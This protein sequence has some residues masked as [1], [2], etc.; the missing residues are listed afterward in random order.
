[1]A[2]GRGGF[3]L[4]ELMIAMSLLGI[5]A[6]AIHETV[7][8]GLRAVRVSHIREDVR[9]QAVRALDRLTREAALCANVDQAQ[10][11][12]FQFDADLD[13]DGSTE[14]NINYR[15]QNG[16]LER[17][18]GGTSVVLVSDLA[19][20]DFDYV[21]EAGAAMATP[22]ASGSRDDVRV[23]QIT[24]TAARGTESISVAGAAYLRNMD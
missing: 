4:L 3:T 12:R 9:L 14:G 16:D 21:D 19:G 7:I 11:Q 22:V 1:M 24:V 8:V 10:D 18:Q 15:V 17:V 2:M 23:V 6:G 5:F 20:L 13:G